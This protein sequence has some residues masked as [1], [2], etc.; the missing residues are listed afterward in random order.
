ME[1]LEKIKEYA[2]QYEKEVREISDQLRE[3]K[4]PAL[5]SNLVKLLYV[6]KKQGE[7][8]LKSKQPMHMVY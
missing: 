7:M 4:M 8:E 5:S 2:A 3:E 6:L 1:L